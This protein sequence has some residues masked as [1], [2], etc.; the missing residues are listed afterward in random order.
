MH[1]TYYTYTLRIIRTSPLR[2]PSQVAEL[3]DEQLP[4]RFEHSGQRR[5]SRPV[6]SGELSGVLNKALAALRS[7]R[8][9]GFSDC[10]G[11]LVEKLLQVVRTCKVRITGITGFPGDAQ[12]LAESPALK[13]YESPTWALKEKNV[14]AIIFLGFMRPAGQKPIATSGGSSK[15]RTWMRSISPHFNPQ[16]EEFQPRTMWSLSNAFTSAF[17]ELE[18]IPQFKATGKLAPFLDSI[19]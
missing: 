13:Y 8:A 2:G 7:V 15:T 12:I 17:K 3:G 10:A 1:P 18:P 14:D 6:H 16:H 4:G 9:H 5:S 19:K 11:R